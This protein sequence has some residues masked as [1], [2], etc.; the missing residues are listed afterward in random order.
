MPRQ[1]AIAALAALLVLSSSTAWAYTCAGKAD[2]EWC[3]F[4]EI[5]ICDGG[6]NVFID[7]C[8]Y[9]CNEGD[10]P[11][12]DC[13]PKPCSGYCCTKSNGQW[14]HNDEVWICSGGE[15]TFA[16]P[17]I[18]G[19]TEGTGPNASCSPPPCSGYCCGKSDGEWCHNDEIWIC[20]NEE[21]VFIDG[22]LYGCDE[23]DGPNGDCSPKPCSGYCCGKADGEWCHN[24]EIWICDDQE[25]VFADPCL[26]G[27]NEGDGP[28]GDCAPNP[29]SGYCCD[30][31]DGEWCHNDEIWICDDQEGVFADPCL[32]G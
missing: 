11:D 9:G 2:G 24:G 16:D 32:Y 22:C 27:C 21:D 19:C 12:A 13:S 26:Y 29:C 10:G 3:H 4:N 30:K 15:N 20:D 25:G 8:L 1:V 14:C 23:G 31:S 5:W 18:W 17:C 6:V 28:D 7:G